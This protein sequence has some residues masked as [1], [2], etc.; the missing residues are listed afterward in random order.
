MTLLRYTA[1]AAFCLVAAWSSASAAAAGERPALIMLV[2]E[3][4]DASVS[5]ATEAISSQISDLEADLA[6]TPV[7][8]LPTTF[9]AALA[10]ARSHARPSG[11]TAIFWVV[12]TEDDA[13]LL[14]LF[15]GDGARALVRRVE[16]PGGPA[17]LEALSVIVRMSIAEL[18]R[19]GRIGV[20]VEAD[21]AAAA[22]V[23]APAERRAAPAPAPAESRRG[24]LRPGVAY[25][26]TMSSNEHPIVQ[27]LDLSLCASPLQ[28]LWVLAGYTFLERI[29]SSG[30]DASISVARHPLRLGVRGAERWSALELGLSLSFVA[31]WTTFRLKTGSDL[32][33]V[34]GDGDFVWG[35]LP[36]ID[37]GVSFTR[38]L[39]V[40][41]SFG[42]EIDLPS[43]S[44]AYEKDGA[45]VVLLDTWNAQP[46]LLVGLAVD[47][48]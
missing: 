45:R 32:H 38:W 21:A 13:A 33:P 27:G 30:A 10:T 20:A 46:H 39:M 23:P 24:W 4:Q 15:E 18:L 26:L 29:E 8:V 28:H 16:G 43:L 7:D 6:L 35:L 37:F 47:V 31:D 3:V 2:P 22:P 44:Y 1:A 48:P 42:A 40:F 14:Y 9:D 34:G 19:G 17:R 25:A 12:E 11:V 41:A 36:A 5:A